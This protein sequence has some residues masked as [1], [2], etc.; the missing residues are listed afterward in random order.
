MIQRSTGTVETIT[1]TEPHSPRN[2]NPSNNAR[3]NLI[4]TDT[5]DNWAS[6]LAG[7]TISTQAL[8]DYLELNEHPN[9]Q[10]SAEALF[11]LRVPR[12]Y[13]EKIRKGDPDDPLLLQVLPS[14]SEHL[15]VKGY[16]NDPLEEKS[17]SP[18]PGLIHKYRSR[19]LLITTQSCA[20]HCRYCFRR[21]FPYSEHRR[22]QAQWQEALDYL[23][24]QA[25]L[26]EVILSGGDPLMLSNKVL[27][28]LLFALDALPQL[29]RIRIHSRL[30][31]SLPQRVDEQLLAT[32]KALSK[33][34]IIVLHCNHPNELGEDVASACHALRETG[35]WLLN[36]SVL[37]K[38]I[39]DDAQTLSDLSEGLMGCQVHP[40]Y[41]FTLDKVAGAAHFDL[42]PE[43][44]MQIYRE[45][46]ANLPGFL[47]PKLVAE[48]PGQKAKTPLSFSWD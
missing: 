27:Q 16:S 1:S 23:T 19:A 21:N 24:E 12:P 33:K 31:S 2:D 9:A 29:K 45:L 43:R 25:D 47:V 13:L 41:L 8:L 11:K 32:F 20:I 30:I 36:Q 39:N 3:L 42:S 14:A 17:F 34:L 15:Q 18:V 4:S 40:Y 5:D 6:L 37:L 28:N 26:N 44:V 38:G 48:I 35:A 46:L 7:S 22:S 10:A